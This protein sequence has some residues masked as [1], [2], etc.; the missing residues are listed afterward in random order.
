MLDNKLI[1]AGA[2]SGLLSNGPN[3]NL[4]SKRQQQPGCFYLNLPLNQSYCIGF[5]T[6]EYPEGP[7]PAI[8]LSEIPPAVGYCGGQLSAGNFCLLAAV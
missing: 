2:K 7:F 4:N 6:R 5:F 3:V 1:R 8:V